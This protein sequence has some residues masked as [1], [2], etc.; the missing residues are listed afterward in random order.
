MKKVSYVE[1][2]GDEF[3]FHEFINEVGDEQ[4]TIFQEIRGAVIRPDIPLGLPGY[5]L[6]FGKKKDKK[7]HVFLAE[8]QYM[9]QDRLFEALK[10]DAER[11]S[12]HLIYTN[13][14]PGKKTWED[15]FYIDLAG[16]LKPIPLHPGYPQGTIEDG[17]NLI[18]QYP[19]DPPEET[20]LQRQMGKSTPENYD[21]PELYAA[22]AL[23]YLLI[24]FKLD[25]NPSSL[26]MFD[27]NRK[28]AERARKKELGKSL[29]NVSR[30]AWAEYD[31]EL[32]DIENENEDDIIKI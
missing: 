10:A 32:E 4:T 31:K 24:G 8:G 17:V 2:K 19:I 23:Y 15:Q 25:E 16:Y 21:S 1:K 11:L 3:I 13:L 9:M 30:A 6:M 14:P 29:D 7:H 27:K 5:Y 12:S 18:Y 20:E 26:T 22:R 28:E